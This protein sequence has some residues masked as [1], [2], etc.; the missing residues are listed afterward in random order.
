MRKKVHISE[1]KTI[2]MVAGNENIYE[3]VIH[4]DVVK[5]WVGIGWVDEGAPTKAQRAKLP[6]VI[7]D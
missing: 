6:T 2:R 3:Q 7:E 1:L 5:R 4:G